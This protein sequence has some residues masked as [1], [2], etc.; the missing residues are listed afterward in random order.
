M[1]K[2]KGTQICI[3]YTKNTGITQNLGTFFGKVIFWKT[4]S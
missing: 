1:K 4:R 2:V 3:I